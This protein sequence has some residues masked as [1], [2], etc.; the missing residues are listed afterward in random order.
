VAPGL[1]VT[2]SVGV[3]QARAT[4]ADFAAVLARADAALYR[5]KQ[6]GRNRVVSDE[7]T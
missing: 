4:D 2:V 7:T 3:A 6:E 5:A 1:R